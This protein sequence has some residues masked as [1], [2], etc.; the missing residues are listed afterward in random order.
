[1]LWQQALIFGVMSCDLTRRQTNCLLQGFKFSFA[2][3]VVVPL[4]DL[5]AVRQAHLQIYGSQPDGIGMANCTVL[6]VFPNGSMTNS[7][8][9]WDRD[10]EMGEAEEAWVSPD[11]GE[12]CRPSVIP[13]SSFSFC[14]SAFNSTF[15]CCAVI[16]RS[17]CCQGASDG[18]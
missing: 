14:F 8:A 10:D 2:P 3:D 7:Y 11:I 12:K 17:R 18:V 5:S 16:R 1:M 15:G 9:M 13:P 6:G 4:S